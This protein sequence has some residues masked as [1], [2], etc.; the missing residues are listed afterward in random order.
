M[1]A[2][3][4]NLPDWMN[5][6]RASTANVRTL[7]HINGEDDCQSR[8]AGKTIIHVSNTHLFAFGQQRLVAMS[9]ALLT[10]K[11]RQGLQ[12]TARGDVFRTYNSTEFTITGPCGSKLLWSLTARA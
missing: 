10:D 4:S 7:I 8:Q 6:L 12:A 9:G 3:M 5:T 11:H 2:L 1:F